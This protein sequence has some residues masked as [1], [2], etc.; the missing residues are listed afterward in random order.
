MF[1][2]KRTIITGATSGIGECIAKT[3]YKKG[4]KLILGGRSPERGGALVSELGANA[5]FV[6][7]DIK[8][9]DANEALVN[10][11]LEQ[12]GELNQVVMCAGQLGIGKLDQLSLVD[13][14]DTIAT[15]LSAVF[16]LLKYALPQ[17]IK[18]GG[19]SVVIIGSVAA[20][21]AFPN[22]PA[23]TASKGALPSLVR[24]V[25]L[26][27]GPEIR[28]N[29]VSPAQIETPLLHNSVQAFDNPDEILKETAAKLPM[30]RIGA[31]DDIA[32]AVMYLL[33]D[34][35]SWVTGTNLT[36]DGGFLAT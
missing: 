10:Q 12:F 5:H 19:G 25:S 18:S 35:A 13:W 32:A 1:E 9:P 20:S 2:N 23:Y 8:S 7:G 4:A 33:S 31:P 27:Y 6:S 22:H 21:H 36:V 16:Y 28:I 15:N 29:M 3:L 30:K 26:D 24:Q 34:S 17:M 11:A 14:E